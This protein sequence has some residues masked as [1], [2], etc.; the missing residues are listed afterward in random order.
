MTDL[1]IDRLFRS[2]WSGLDESGLPSEKTIHLIT[3]FA[4]FVLE[5]ESEQVAAFDDPLN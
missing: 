5:A 2:W 4:R 3:R 1:E